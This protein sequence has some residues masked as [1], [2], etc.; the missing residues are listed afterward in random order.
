MIWLKLSSDYSISIIKDAICKCNYLCRWH[1]FFAQFQTK[2][3][4]CRKFRTMKLQSFT[5][6]FLLFIFAVVPVFL[7]FL[8][9]GSLIKN[10]NY[11]LPGI[12]FGTAIFAIWDIRFLQLGIWTLNPKYLTGTEFFNLP[13]EE[14]LFFVL[15]PLSAFSIYDFVKTKFQGFEKPNLFLTISLILLLIFGISAYLTRQKLFPFFTFFLL[16]V[17]FAYIIFR[18]RFKKHYTKF[19]LTYLIMLVPYVIFSAI[20]NTL[21]VKSY[22]V[23][24][25]I[26]V[27]VFYSPIENLAYLFLLLLINITIFENLKTRKLI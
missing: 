4:L 15:V 10:L 11:K 8:K 23:V 1:L 9:K 19:Y 22:D 18:N 26:N 17:Y 16:T 6:L 13:L 24:H 12:I 7:A 3:Y 20:L 27:P 14:Y 2:K 5:Y 21:P 25:Q